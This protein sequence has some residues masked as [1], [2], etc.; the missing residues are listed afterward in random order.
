MKTFIYTLGIFALFISPVTCSQ[1]EM[2]S[3]NTT[4]ST[5]NGSITI[6]DDNGNVITIDPTKPIPKP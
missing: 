4:Y 5:A 1:D 6:T 2:N 3:S